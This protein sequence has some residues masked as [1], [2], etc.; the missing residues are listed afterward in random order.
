M[1]S[2][3]IAAALVTASIAVLGTVGCRARGGS[4][5][6]SRPPSH[7]IALAPPD[8]AGPQDEGIALLQARVRADPSV[9]ERWLELGQAWIKKARRSGDAGLHLAAKDAA[10][11]ALE[12]APD[13]RGAL[14]LRGLVLLNAHRFEDARRLANE[15]LERD[16]SDLAALGILSDALV[17]LGEIDEAV[18]VTQRLVDLKPN[19]PSYLRASHLLWLQGDGAGALE[20]ARLAVDAAS[21]E[22]DPEPRAWALVH[23]ATLRR[24]QG[25]YA[26]ADAD[27][28][29]ALRLAP[30]YPPALAAKRKM[31]LS[32]GDERARSPSIPVP[33]SAEERGA[34]ASGRAP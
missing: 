31:A 5:P 12:R 14:V 2:R 22:R 32:R 6:A 26:A 21:D 10:D 11:A 15:L 34:V 17:E 24:H 30:G 29:R 33:R 25:D 16:R 4:S 9:A 1:T 20:V 7:A 27:L 3:W 18:Q 19:L 13:L 8:G 23:A 28:D